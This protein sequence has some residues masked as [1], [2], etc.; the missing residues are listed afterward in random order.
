MAHRRLANFIKRYVHLGDVKETDQEV[1]EQ[2][3]SG[4]QREENSFQAVADAT[5]NELAGRRAEEVRQERQHYEEMLEECY[6]LY[7]RGRNGNG[8]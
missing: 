2:L 8:E 6:S 7:A 4:T 1:L 3:K 5:G